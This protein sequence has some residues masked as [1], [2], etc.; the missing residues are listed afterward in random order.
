MKKRAAEPDS[1]AAKVEAL[2]R[3]PGIYFFKDARGE[4]VY[5]GKAVSL[6]DRVKSYFQP[7]SDP[8]VR[9]I[10]R[11]TADVDYL[12]TDS[13]KDAVFLESNY[14]RNVQPRF[15]L[16]LKDDKSFPYLKL[17]V[18]D[19]VPGV[20]FTR[21]VA[22]DGAR[23][24]GPFAPPGQA[25]RTIRIINTYFGVRGCEEKIPGRRSRPCL[26]HELG[27]CAAPCVSAVSPEDY[28][29]RVRNALLLLEG[30]TEELKSIL[31]VKMEEAAA[32]ED[33]EQAAW[34][35]DA[36]RAVEDVKTGS[37]IIS[38]DRRDMD[39]VGF[40]REGGR[41]AVLIFLMRQGKVL[42]S[43]PF[44]IEAPL[45]RTPAE[46][47]AGFLAG[48][49]GKD[50]P[51]VEEILVPF[52]PAAAGDL[53][54]PLLVP[55]R[56]RKKQLMAFAERNALLLLKER[57]SRG[58]GLEELGGVLGVRH[59]IRRIEGF[60]VSNTGGTESVGS[61][62]VFVDGHPRRSDYRKFKI[63]TVE[64]PND[65]AGLN[66]VIARRYRRSLAERT[67][68]PDLVFVDG[69]KPQ[70]G[71]ALR[72]LREMGLVGIPVVGLAKREEVIFREGDKDGLRLERSSEALKLLQ[73][74]RDEAHRF[75]ITFHRARRQKASLN[76]L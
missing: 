64:G 8:K 54:L 72:T 61:L 55:K 51:G 50:R 62:V 5:I 59:P 68:L 66:E 11:E 58:S 47:L 6:Q 75:A 73:R 32:R 23:Y 29:E 3:A 41:A 56:G 37:R 76:K 36:I 20:Y 40:G 48:H 33:F 30:R 2:P 10:L 13:E 70:L 44:L 15:N 67:P 38:P 46:I 52:E 63:K 4:I 26:D 74:V 16:R 22:E 19:A 49:Y 12:L 28:R 60:D 17:T 57:T 31:T 45:E 18:G 53:R 25:R 7:T 39:I 9:A 42:E 35:R 69:G 27:L 43:K 34:W 65:V 1:L 21:K 14:I 24:F 71:A